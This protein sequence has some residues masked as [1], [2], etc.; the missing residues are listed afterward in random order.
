MT[1]KSSAAWTY[2]CQAI[3]SMSLSWFT[4]TEW[5]SFLWNRRSS[6]ITRHP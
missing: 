2:V 1:P 6:G 3:S 4:F 5:P